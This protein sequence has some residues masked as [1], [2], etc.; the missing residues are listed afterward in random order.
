[1][2]GIET[3]TMI[4]S[5]QHQF[6]F[7]HNPKCAGTSF[8][9]HIGHLHDD[10]T[11]FWDIFYNNYLG[12]RQDYAHLRLWELQMNH[13]ALL[14]RLRHYRSLV[15][16]RS[17]FRRFVSALLQHIRAYRPELDFDGLD[18]AGQHRAFNLVIDQLSIERVMT[19][20]RYV[21]FS[22]QHWF[23]RLPDN[24]YP[25]T[26][27]PIS[28][29]P[30]SIL[31]GFDA[32]GVPRGDPETRNTAPFSCLSILADPAILLFIRDFYAADFEIFEKLR[33]PDW[34]SALPAA[35][36]LAMA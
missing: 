2:V 25:W 24:D 17:P 9:A 29:S 11:T 7:I 12:I 18:R 35:N 36:E 22:P 8:R 5:H 3:V 10:G 33:L 26:I 27:L 28:D 34:L 31:P 21:H 4:I 15:F 13:G 6:V 20:F 14:N 30:E 32:L 23:L 1:M 19:D 16:V